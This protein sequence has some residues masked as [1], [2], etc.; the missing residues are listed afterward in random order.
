MKE[1]SPA[2]EGFGGGGFFLF[3]DDESALVCHGDGDGLWIFH[4]EGFT[5][6]FLDVN[7]SL[8]NKK[9]AEISADFDIVRC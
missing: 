5:T 4:F 9:S 6:L 7:T 1:E 2:K 8:S 3:D